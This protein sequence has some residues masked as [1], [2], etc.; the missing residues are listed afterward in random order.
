MQKQKFAEAE[1]K[2]LEITAYDKEAISAIYSDKP[3]TFLKIFR[4]DIK[5][6]KKLRKIFADIWL[7]RAGDQIIVKAPRGGGKSEFLGSLGFCLWYFKDYSIVDMGGSFAQAKIVYNYFTSIIFS[8]ERIS[9]T[10]EKEPTME[11]TENVNGKY[12][13]CVAASPK[14]VRGPHPDALLGDEV[15]EIK[16]D[17]ID[18][19]IPMVDASEHPITILTSTFHKV[20]GFFQETWDNAE[21]LGYKRYSWDIFD[22]VKE[23]D[24]AIWDN[25]ELNEQIPDL[26]KLK[27]MAKGRNGD[28]D[29]WVPVKNIIKAWRSK[30]SLDWFMVEYMGSRPSVAGLVLNPEDVDTSIFD[31]EQETCYNYTKGAECI[32]GIDWGFSSMT[33]VVDFMRYKNDQVVELVSQNYEQVRSEII[34][35][36]VVEMVEAR[37]HQFIYADSAGKFEN[38]DLQNELDK[39]KLKC[40]VIEVVFSKYKEEMVGNY[41]AYFEREKIKIPASHKVAKWQHKRYRYQPGTNKPVKKDDHVPDATM[42]ALKHWMLGDSEPQ[43]FKD[44]NNSMPSDSKPLTAGLRDAIF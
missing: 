10:I 35:R 36:D 24:S 2:I 5:H 26:Q 43:T 19:A 22:V 14:S 42:C 37:G 15:C 41:R 1:Q 30:R 8:D 16:D 20:F 33:A 38:A 23:F 13:K 34:I 28:P 12:F 32:I 21:A 40:E 25:K 4:P 29:G 27:A 7:G 3:I 17:L 39:K 11:K 18:S 6:P 9:K 44:I 31:D